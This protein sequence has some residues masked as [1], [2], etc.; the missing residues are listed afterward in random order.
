MSEHGRHVDHGAA[1]FAGELDCPALDI[2]G[3]GIGK[4]PGIERED[5]RGQ[6]ENDNGDAGAD[7]LMET[8]EERWHGSGQEKSYIVGWRA[9]FNVLLQEN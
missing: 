1:F 4:R 8:L 9:F 7:G 6:Q 5:Q 2:L 3:A